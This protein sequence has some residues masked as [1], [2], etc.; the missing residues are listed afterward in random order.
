VFQSIV[1]SPNDKMREQLVSALQATGEVTVARTMERYP[2][3]IDLVR[4]LRAHGVEL[5][6]LDFGSTEK[7]LEIVELLER[8]SNHVQIAAFHQDMDPMI[9]QQT[10]RVG[11]REFLVQPFARQAVLEALGRIKTLLDRRPVVYAASNQIFSFLPSKA[12]VGT[13]VIALN[14]S[15]AMARKA[16]TKVL[17]ADFD[18]NSGMMRFMLKLGNQ[19][20]VQDA[21]ERAEHMDDGLWPQMVTDVNGMDVLHAGGVRPNLR[22]EPSQIRN[23]VAFARRHYQ[24]LCFDLSG[25]LEKYSMELMHECKR[26]MLVCTPEI[27]SLHLTREKLA[28][29]RECDLADRVSI[30]LNRAHKKALF[31][32]Q[33]VEDLLGRAVDR[34]FPNDYQGINQAAAEGTVVAESSPIG[35]ATTEFAATLL[36]QGKPKPTNEKHKFLEH[37]FTASSLV[38]G[39]H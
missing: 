7:A 5:L 23:L 31:N 17:L 25:N 30:I 33:Q 6:F 32:T 10:M 34:V 15:A 37:F 14:T 16:D 8:E 2:T 19:N 3:A 22:I 39:R 38:P 20:S 24:V 1:I 4:A 11:V 27:P 12:G 36:E 29:L 13:S 28:F 21:V 18:L 26:I 9:L 35:K